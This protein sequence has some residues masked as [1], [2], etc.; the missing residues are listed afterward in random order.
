MNF[1]PT[2][3][4]RYIRQG[5]SPHA[6]YTV[7]PRLL[8]EL[9]LI[10]RHFDWP[11]AMHIAESREELELLRDGTGPFRELLEE[12]SMWD[13][14][15]VPRGS[16]PL[17]Y[18]RTLAKAPRAIVIHGNYLDYEELRFLGANRDR[19]SLVFC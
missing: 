14:G 6:P 11:M 15:A 1:A 3:N 12:R 10:A 13:E 2:P 17:D 9:I 7:S 5:F 8:K 19:M 16:Q 4:N 18:L